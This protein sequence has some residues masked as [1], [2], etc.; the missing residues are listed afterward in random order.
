MTAKY[1]AFFFALITTMLS[2]CNNDQNTDS[3][4]SLLPPSVM[5][6]LEVSMPQEKTEHSVD[7]IDA[8]QREIKQ[9]EPVKQALIESSIAALKEKAAND[10]HAQY[11]LAMMH[12]VG[13]NG[14]EKNHSQAISMLEDAAR[15]GSTQAEV[16]LATLLISSA[17]DADREKALAMYE[18]GIAD[19]DVDAM[20]N[21][22]FILAYKNDGVTL[23][24]DKGRIE[25][26]KAY[27]KEAASKGDVFSQSA[28]GEIY[29]DEGDY[30]EA[31]KWLENPALAGVARGINRLMDIIE[32]KPGSV[33]PALTKKIKTMYGDSK[34]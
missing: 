25:K 13:S 18:K 27:L 9:P 21:A 16:A 6:D 11:E 20:R 8:K 29:A 22:A 3:K 17:D 28:L 5:A 2:G 26:A 33:P 12:L 19:G 32:I 10:P 4:V 14:V 34:A 7:D 31:V 1:P 24:E 15:K 23:I 30:A